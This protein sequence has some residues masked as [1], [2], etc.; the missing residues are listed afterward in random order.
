M[1]CHCPEKQK[2]YY[3]HHRHIYTFTFIITGIVIKHN[4]LEDIIIISDEELEQDN[5][6]GNE[7]RLEECFGFV[8]GSA[9][10]ETVSE[11]EC[12]F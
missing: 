9:G 5:R 1:T 10:S 2:C 4:K 7:L 12:H 8:R 3:A 11:Q 6:R